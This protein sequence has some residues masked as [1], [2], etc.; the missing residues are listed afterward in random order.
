MVLRSRATVSGLGGDQGLAGG[1]IPAQH[2]H[3]EVAVSPMDRRQFLARSAAVAGGLAVAGPLEAFRTRVAAAQSVESAGYGPLVDM[4]DLWLPEGFQYRIISSRGDDMSDVD[5]A[6]GL[7]FPT[8]SRFDGMAAFAGPVTGDTIL[9][10]NHENRSR[11]LMFMDAETR[12]EVPNPY[13]PV[14]RNAADGQFCKGGV[15]KLVVRD[16]QVLSS[17]ALLG[18]TIWNCAGGATPWNTWIT[19]EE[20]AANSGAMGAPIPHGYI[21]EVDAFATGPVEPL[22][23]KPAGRFDHE[24]VVWHDESLY[25]TEDRNGACFYRYTPTPR[26]SKAGDLAASTGPLD[27]LVVDS[28]SNLDTSTGWPAAF[29]EPLS[30]SWVTVPNPDPTNPNSPPNGVRHQAQALGAAVFERTEGCWLG[31]DRIYFDCTTGGP[32]GLGQVWELDPRAMELRL[33]FQSDDAS[34]LFHP[35][36]L[37]VA[38]TDDLF[39]CE[40]VGEAVAPHIRGLTP[41]GLIYDFARAARGGLDVGTNW[42]EFCGACFSSVPR[43]KPRSGGLDLSTLTLYVNQQGAASET[44]PPEVTYAI[45]GPWKRD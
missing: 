44:G 15:T 14:I 29:G 41:D 12:V 4:G 9:I 7:P 17:T 31:D 8:P 27:A 2:E 37:A 34:G 24:A 36:N 38:P 30:V 42:T 5:P 3:E 28:H 10:R 20:E 25:L 11:R 19:C 13:D 40:D 32:A 33:I 1:R 23:I 21:F 45:W 18:G 43:P 35:D 22:P 26:P 6:T 16:R 39:I